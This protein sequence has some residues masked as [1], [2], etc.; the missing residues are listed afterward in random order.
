[1]VHRGRGEVTTF[2][3]QVTATLDCGH[4]CVLDVHSLMQHTP[5]KCW[6]CSNTTTVNAMRSVVT[7]R[8]MT[9]GWNFRCRNCGYA[10]SYGTAT[11][12]CQTKAASHALRKA[13]NVEI[14]VDRHIQS[15]VETNSP[16]LPLNGK[17]PF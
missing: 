11:M 3:S 4:Q 15:V 16:L 10:R 8:G 13:H 6:A 17:A 1:M 9:S 5:V 7:F 12:T 14:R 2:D